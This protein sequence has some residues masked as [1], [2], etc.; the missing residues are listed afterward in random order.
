[1]LK[2]CF[3]LLVIAFLYSVG[4]NALAQDKNPHFL[5]TLAL[6]QHHSGNITAAVEIEQRA[7][8]L[9]TPND[10]GL[11]QVFESRLAEYREIE[12]IVRAASGDD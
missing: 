9:L 12:S 2:I 11:Q 8:A 7:I 6:A 10:A 1:M 3:Q 4:P 5:D